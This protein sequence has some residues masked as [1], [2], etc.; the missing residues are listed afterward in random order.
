MK[1]MG[2]IHNGENWIIRVQGNEHPPVHVHVLCPE[3]RAVV[4]LNGQ[5]INSH[6]PAITLKRAQEWIAEHHDLIHEEWAR[7]N[8]PVKR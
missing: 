7:M 8:N 4:Y 6:V 1:V 3:G 5:T 2:K